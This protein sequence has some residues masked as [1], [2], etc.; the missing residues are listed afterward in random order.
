MFAIVYAALTRDLDCTHFVQVKDV[1][2]F[3]LR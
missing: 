3:N 2:R 1:L